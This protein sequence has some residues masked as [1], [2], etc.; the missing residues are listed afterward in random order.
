[1]F[2]WNHGVLECWE[3]SMKEISFSFAHSSIIPFFHHSIL[4]VFSH[5]VGTLFTKRGRFG[6]KVKLPAHRAGLPGN[7]DTITASAFLPA[8]KA[9][10]PADLPVAIFPRP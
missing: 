7:V 8:Y 4:P 2:L 3:E 1:M 9:G 10:P 6:M 5:C